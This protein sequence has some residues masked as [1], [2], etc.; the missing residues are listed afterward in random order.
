VRGGGRALQATWALC[1][2]L[3]CE[4]RDGASV[5]SAASSTASAASATSSTASATAA[6][7]TASA[8]VASAGAASATGSSASAGGART[9]RDERAGDAVRGWLAS[10][11]VV[12][13]AQPKME[14][15]RLEG[16]GVLAA[17]LEGAGEG[18]AG[19]VRRAAVLSLDRSSAPLAH[20]RPLAYARLAQAL[21]AQIVPATVERHLRAGEVMALLQGQGVL[22][23]RVRKELS[24]QNDGTVTALLSAPSP[25]ALGDAWAR[26]STSV[27]NA[28]SSFV[29]LRWEKWASSA[30]PVAGESR[31]L[32]RA[33][34]EM[35]ALDYLAAFG[36]RRALL[37]VPEQEAVILEDNQEA[38]PPNV[39]KALLDPLLR[40][41]RAVARF[42]RG[43]RDALARFDRA[44][45]E[46]A[47]NSGSFEEWLLSPRSLVE[48]SERRASLLSL[49]EAQIALRGEEAVLSL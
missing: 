6:S 28:K 12:A 29:V 9:S 40:R 10:A 32:V 45:A 26:P 36:T 4:G 31:R 48:L 34:V 30:T 41:L 23:A 35:I 25:E 19:M 5:T 7:S 21:G 1:L 44:S 43:L 38:F 39:Q 13:L 24:I 27:L 22:E 18:D 47:L 46:A 42:P 2:A 37:F 17:T 49:I 15:G 3:G 14:A 16:P 20:R 11:E 8:M 33:F